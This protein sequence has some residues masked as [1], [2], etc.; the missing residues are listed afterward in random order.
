MYC[1]EHSDK[2]YNKSFFKFYSDVSYI[3]MKNGTTHIQKK[4]EIF[5]L[6]G[7][8]TNLSTSEDITFLL[9]IKHIKYTIIAFT[10]VLEIFFEIILKKKS[11][12]P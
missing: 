6:C 1:T 11:T 8:S 7:T 3:T 10:T 4:N 5:I 12:F 9:L 2:D